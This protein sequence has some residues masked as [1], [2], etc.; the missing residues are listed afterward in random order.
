MPDEFV[1]FLHHGRPVWGLRKEQRIH[2]CAAAPW[3]DER[4]SGETVDALGVEFLAPAEPSKIVC[5]GVNYQDHAQEMGHSLPEEPL[6]FLK[7]STSLLDVGKTIHLP[8][9]VGRV[10]HEAE[11]ALVIGKTVGPRV[12]NDDALFG[13]TCAND[14]TARELQKKD[15]QWTRAK[16]FD[17]F[18][19]LGPSLVRGLDASDLSIECLVNGELRQGSRT[20]QLI[21]LPAQLVNFV[22][23]IMTL[24]PGD[25]ILTGTPAGIGPL[26]AGDEVEVRIQ[27]LGS[28][29]NL[30]I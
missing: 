11:L 7:P 20:S 21:F 29:S 12:D 10:D 25:V 2:L 30:V 4:L 26:S 24:N 6:I 15:G 27:G 13:Y 22:A 14:V 5:V 18:C 8:R 9:G 3:A 28:L 19:P 16:G 17:T 23:G 1:R